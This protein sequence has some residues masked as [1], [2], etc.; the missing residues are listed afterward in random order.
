LPNLLSYSGSVMVIDP[1]GA[2]ALITAKRRREMGQE[3]YIVDP[4]NIASNG[5]GAK[6]NP[7]EW[8]VAGDIDITENAKLLADAL[9]VPDGDGD[10]F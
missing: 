4:W 2:N 10:K 1:K 7:L 5:E 8:L 3:V 9:I 6:F